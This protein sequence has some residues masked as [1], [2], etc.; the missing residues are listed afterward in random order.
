MIL[1]YFRVTAP[2]W[3]NTFWEDDRHY[4][5]GMVSDMVDN[6]LMLYDAT[7]VCRV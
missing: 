3:Y 6:R 5:E 1:S 7:V 2:T 4:S